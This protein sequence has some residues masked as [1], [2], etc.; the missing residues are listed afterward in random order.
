MADLKAAAHEYWSQGC[1]NKA[2]L[3]DLE[4]ELAICRKI[5]KGS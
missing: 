4:N 2:F 1:N 3:T 5:L